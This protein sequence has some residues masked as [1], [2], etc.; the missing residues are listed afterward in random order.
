MKNIL[1]ATTVLAGFASA[2]SAE[3][4]FSGMG[5]F[6]VSYNNNVAAGVAKAQVSERFRVNIDG[7]TVTDGGVTFGG[8]VRLQSDAGNTNALLSA[9]QLYASANG[10][11]LEVGNV[12]EALDSVALFYDSEVGYI[13]NSAGEQGGFDSFSSGPYGA[14]DVNRMG[15]F[16][17]Y[18]AGPLN[19]RVSYINHDQTVTK[20][21]LGTDKEI[22]VSADYKFGQITVAAGAAKNSGGVKD[23]F[24]NFV[25]AAYAL[26]PDINVGLNYYN[27]GAPATKAASLVTLYGNYT[28]GALTLRGYVTKTNATVKNQT[29]PGIGADYALGGGVTLSGSIRPDF[30]GKTQADMGVKFNF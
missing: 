13:G 8:R 29:V 4:T 16:F 28:M 2:A 12:N 9:G 1:L 3:I 17:G 19:A 22:S 18:S 20:S 15:V 25:G 6:G 5:R 30:A 26:S 11:R 23:A 21:A 24:N 27:A 10:L 7:K 14:G